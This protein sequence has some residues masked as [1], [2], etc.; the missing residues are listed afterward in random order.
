MQ[1]RALENTVYVLAAGAFG[2]FL[3]WLQLQLAFDDKGLCGPSV[4]NVIVPLFL[5]VV[6]VVLRRRIGKMLDGSFTIPEG[7][8][9]S[10]A[11]PGKFYT[12]L[13]WAAGA[14]VILGGV[15]MIRGSE[16]EKRVIMLRILGGL[17]ILAGLCYPLFMT[18]ANRELKPRRRVPLCLLAL[19]PILLFAV[20]LVYCYVCNAI[21]SVAWA[22]LIEVLTVSTLML[23]FFRLAGF[24]YDQIQM[25][26]TLFWI[27]YGVFMSLVAL[28]DSRSIGMQAVFFGSGFVLALTDFILLRTLR[29]KTEEEFAAEEKPPKYDGGLEKL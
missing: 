7:F 1:N 15:L 29:V 2:V 11:N 24:V 9:E 3:R 6:A 23:A 26:K 8:H 12:F 19:V 21:N 25:K 13:R 10:L 14:V 18:L 28:A 16:V 17:A 22:Y 5:I 27:Q 4:F 20:W